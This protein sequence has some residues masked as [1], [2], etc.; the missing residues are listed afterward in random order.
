MSVSVHR[1]AGL[2]FTWQFEK[3]KFMW[4]DYWLRLRHTSTYR[5]RYIYTVSCGLLILTPSPLLTF[6]T[7][8][9]SSGTTMQ[10]PYAWIVTRQYGLHVDMWGCDEALTEISTVMECILLHFFKF[11]IL[12]TLPTYVLLWL[13]MPSS[14]VLL[15]T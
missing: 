11:L 13:C 12:I 2:L 8:D 4:W 9:Q 10:C 1:M 6:W 14:P 7:S 3:A 5:L 15:L